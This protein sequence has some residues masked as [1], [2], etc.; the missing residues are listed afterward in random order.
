MQ[1]LLD[2]KVVLWAVTSNRELK[3]STRELLSRADVI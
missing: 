1:L 2:T 3:S